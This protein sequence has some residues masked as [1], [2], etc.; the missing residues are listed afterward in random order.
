VYFRSGAQIGG[1]RLEV[2]EGQDA[3]GLHPYV[4]LSENFI[5]VNK[6]QYDPTKVA[7]K[8]SVILVDLTVGG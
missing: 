7:V 2:V 8:A 4:S 3:P 5:A 1:T 6:N